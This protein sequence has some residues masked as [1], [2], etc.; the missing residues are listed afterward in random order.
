MIVFLTFFAN[1]CSNCLNIHNKVSAD[2][3][4]LSSFK[5]CNA[6]YKLLYLVM[7]KKDTIVGESTKQHNTCNADLTYT[8]SR[9]KSAKVETQASNRVLKQFVL[10]TM[11]PTLRGQ[12]R[13]ALDL[14][15]QNKLS[16]NGQHRSK[17]L[18]DVNKPQP[19]TV[20]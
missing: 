17:G 10:E 8:E 9:S 3:K 14:N 1:T 20:L 11:K 19:E 18:C 2:L 15:I 4:G 7:N 6:R 5:P 13:T 12:Q 16:V